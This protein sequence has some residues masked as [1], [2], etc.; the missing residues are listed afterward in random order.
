[1]TAQSQ[2][3]PDPMAPLCIALPPEAACIM[4]DALCAWVER[5]MSAGHAT[6]AICRL[7]SARLMASESTGATLS[8]TMNGTTGTGPSCQGALR[9]WLDQARGYGR[10]TA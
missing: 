1:M 5:E 3:A 7:V 9:D 6:A 8:V 2:P 10:E 4:R